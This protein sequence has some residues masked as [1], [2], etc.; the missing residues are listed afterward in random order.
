MVGAGSGGGSAALAAATGGRALTGAL[1]AGNEGGAIGAEGGIAGSAGETG[2]AAA[3]ESAG[4]R[5]GFNLKRAASCVS[6]FGAAGCTA[7]AEVAAGGGGKLAMTAGV[8][9]VGVGREADGAA[10]AVSASG[11]G[12]ALVA[13][14]IGGTTGGASDGEVGRGRSLKPPVGVSC[15]GSETFAG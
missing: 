12:M 15:A 7:G 1:A 9:A 14:A 4:P 13:V 8:A 5:R 10:T 3:V 6:T 11:G 2:F